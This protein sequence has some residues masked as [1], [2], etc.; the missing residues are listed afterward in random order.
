[1]S[2]ASDVKPTTGKTQPERGIPRLQPW[3]G[4]KY[5]Q[6]STGLSI[7]EGDEGE[8]H[9]HL[10]VQGAEAGVVC[11]EHMERDSCDDLLTIYTP[12]NQ[13]VL[14]PVLRDTITGLGLDVLDVADAGSDGLT[15]GDV[16]Y[17]VTIRD[18]RSAAQREVDHDTRWPERSAY[19]RYVSSITPRRW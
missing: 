18:P 7:R 15:A 9:L 13:D 19:Q 14:H 3:G 6:G 4:F 10:Y 12:V 1:M 16:S 11:R 2:K 8:L 17:T 5:L